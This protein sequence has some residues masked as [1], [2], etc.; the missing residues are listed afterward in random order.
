MESWGSTIALYVHILCYVHDR[1]Q[2]NVWRSYEFRCAG[3]LW[4]FVGGVP[5]FDAVVDLPRLRKLD[6]LESF[7]MKATPARSI[8]LALLWRTLCLPDEG[9]SNQATAGFRAIQCLQEAMIVQVHT[10]SD[11]CG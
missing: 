3:D 7:A 5:Y 2:R 8:Q 4:I 6:L 10:F 1:L 11:G 9:C